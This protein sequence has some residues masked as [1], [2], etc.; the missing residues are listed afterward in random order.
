[1]IGVSFREARKT[2]MVKKG[3]VPP[4]NQELLEVIRREEWEQRYAL[5]HYLLPP[6]RILPF[7]DICAYRNPDHC[8]EMEERM[9]N[10]T[11]KEL[12]LWYGTITVSR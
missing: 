7:I 6:Y 5:P 4:S 2:E 10:R 9:K 11:P 12:D 8:R 1:M 3:E